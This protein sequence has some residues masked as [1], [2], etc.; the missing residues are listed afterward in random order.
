MK[1]FL[2]IILLLPNF[3]FSQYINNSLFSFGIGY[4]S[5]DVEIAERGLL[6][7]NM[8]YINERK[9][10]GLDFGFGK[11]IN[12]EQNYTGY[13]SQ[14]RW[15]ED[16]ESLVYSQFMFA[17]RFGYEVLPRVYL[18]GTL[19]ANF[20]DQ[21]QERFDEFYILGY[22]GRYFV[23]TRNSKTEPYIKASAAFRQERFLIEA[24][25]SNTG[26]AFSLSFILF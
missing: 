18:I 6:T 13:V 14:F 11:T 23:S 16:I 24:G 21:F 25:F 8:D 5:N 12:E 19:G 4:N 9:L 20:F 1:K 22:D 3:L 15:A 10:Y 26:V 17:G 7:I 2:F